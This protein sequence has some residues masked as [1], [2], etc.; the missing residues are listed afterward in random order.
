MRS[1]IQL[2]QELIKLCKKWR[3]IPDN[4]HLVSVCQCFDHR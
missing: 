1:G 2:M 4:A 3:P